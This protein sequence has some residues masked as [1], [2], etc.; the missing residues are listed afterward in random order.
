MA[1]GGRAV[2]RVCVR[3]RGLGGGF[4]PS[5]CPLLLP[6]GGLTATCREEGDSGVDLS[7]T[8]PCGW[9]A[10]AQVGLG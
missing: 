3:S 10:G 6:R 9:G 5:T 1:R 7:G 2:W 4:L 8:V